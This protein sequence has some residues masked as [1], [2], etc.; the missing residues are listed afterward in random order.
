MHCYTISDRPAHAF[1]AESFGMPT[2]PKIYRKSFLTNSIL[3]LAASL[4]VLA[5]TYFYV[6][7]ERVFYWTDW[8]L[9]QNLTHVLWQAFQL[10]PQAAFTVLSA[11]ISDDYNSLFAV[12]ILPFYYV[13]GESRLVFESGLALVYLLPFALVLG[14]IA[15]RLI[16]APK[17]LV[18]WST[19]LV[20]L[21]TPVLWVPLLRGYP[22]VVSALLIGLAVWIVLRDITLEHWWTAV[23]SGIFLAFAVLLRRH[24]A[25]EGVSFF[26]ALTLSV[27]GAELSLLLRERQFKWKKYLAKVSFLA[28]TF[29]TFVIT[30]LLVGT[31]FV[32]NSLSKNTL[33]LY[34]SF[35]FPWTTVIQ[36]FGAMY[37]WLTWA[38]A[39][40][41]LA[42]GFYSRILRKRELGFFILFAAFSAALWFFLVRQL[43][44]HYTLHTTPVMV[45][46]LV[47]FGWV[48]YLKS[49]GWTRFGVIAGSALF[50]LTMMVAGLAPIGLPNNRVVHT[51]LPIQEPPQDD[52]NYDRYAEIVNFLR[53]EVSKDESIYIASSGPHLDADRIRNAERTMYGWDDAK[54]D[55][56]NVPLFDSRDPYPL[57]QLLSAKYVVFASGNQKREGVP[58]RQGVNRVVFT[59]FRSGQGLAGDFELLPVSFK[60]SNKYV[61]HVYKRVRPTDAATALASFQIIQK[62]VLERTAPQTDWISL[63]SDTPGKILKDDQNFTIVFNYRALLN[64]PYLELLYTG[65]LTHVSALRGNL[66]GVPDNCPPLS[67]ELTPVSQDG[68]ALHSKR[69]LVAQP[70]PFEIQLDSENA[71]Y[72]LMKLWRESDP[73]PAGCH[74]V[75]HDLA[76]S[77]H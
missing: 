69:A 75:I 2:T 48:C 45:I 39:L 22:D 6:S 73:V 32:R 65:D 33:E 42:L 54:L 19:V 17:R 11:S 8:A 4:F 61:V 34:E 9:Y 44:V 52:K 41:G 53:Q 12:P 5:F 40:S 76:V 37:G 59:L 10:S 49:K 71:G 15:T 74:V 23:S 77:P 68:R 47:A 51:I 26:V 21:L 36:Y 25:Y 28:L 3:L 55:L 20:A 16:V 13:L 27:L 58:G 18:F 31:P 56:L 70:G 24:F 64:I 43:G 14:A 7:A 50:L 72:L 38:L 46:G 1:L 66:E 62:A 29:L 60:L 67:I 35:V 30:L 57:K 63:N